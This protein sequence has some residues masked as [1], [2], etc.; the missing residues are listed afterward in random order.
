MFAVEFL[1][2]L[3]PEEIEQSLPVPLGGMLVVDRLARVERKAVVRF[4]VDLDRRI[5]FRKVDDLLKLDQRLG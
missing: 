1:S 2:E 5:D 4:F 3:A